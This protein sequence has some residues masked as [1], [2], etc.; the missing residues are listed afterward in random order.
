ME[1]KDVLGDICRSSMRKSHINLFT[2][3]QVI[4]REDDFTHHL[5][6][7]ELFQS[8]DTLKPFKLDQKVEILLSIGLIMQT[9]FMF[10]YSTLGLVFDE[11][12]RSEDKWKLLPCL[13]VQLC[14]IVS[15][16]LTVNGL[17]FKKKKK[18]SSC[19]RASAEEYLQSEFALD[20][21]TLVI[22]VVD[23]ATNFE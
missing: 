11:I 21:I 3:K 16:F 13:V 20:F 10:F 15:K 23:M 5:L 7:D 17:S 12:N 19:L 6:E 1:E 9:F 4:V 8:E 22:I 14:L 2:R 18:E